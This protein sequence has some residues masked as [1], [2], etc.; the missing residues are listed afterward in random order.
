M[1]ACPV[2]VARESSGRASLEGDA[3]TAR[4]TWPRERGM[5]KLEDVPWRFEGERPAVARP[6]RRPG[7]RW[8]WPARRPLPRPPCPRSRRRGRR[9]P[10]RPGPGALRRLAV[11]HAARSPEAGSRPG[12]VHG[13]PPGPLGRGDGARRQPNRRGR[14]PL[15]RRRLPAGPRPALRRHART[16]RRRLR[17]AG[18]ARP[19]R[20]RRATRQAGSQNPRRAGRAPSRRG[21]GPGPRTPRPRPRRPPRAR[22]PRPTP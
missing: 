17:A 15:P 6:G 7:R 3:V 19:D 4:T 22:T 1:A 14:R 8:S 11:E 9:E 2:Q 21:G 10:S 16:R 20:R 18:P 5:E 12:R 13:R